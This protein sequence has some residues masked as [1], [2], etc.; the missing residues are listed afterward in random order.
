MGARTVKIF[1][2]ILARI[3]RVMGWFFV[4]IWSLFVS[5]ELIVEVWKKRKLIT[6]QIEKRW[7]RVVGGNWIR[8]PGWFFSQKITSAASKST[9]FP[10]SCIKLEFIPFTLV[11]SDSAPQTWVNGWRNWRHA[12]QCVHLLLEGPIWPIWYSLEAVSTRYGNHMESHWWVPKRQCFFGSRKTI[13][14]HT[15]RHRVV[16]VT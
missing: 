6:R 14:S 4:S 13:T 2:H 1:F 15:R 16:W 12:Y 3:P 9:G 5:S 7:G 10:I 8:I 11:P